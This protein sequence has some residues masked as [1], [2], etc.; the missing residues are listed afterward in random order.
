[1]F[2]YHR[3]VEVTTATMQHASG[4]VNTVLRRHGR[5]RPGAAI[6]ATTPTTIAEPGQNVW[7]PSQTRAASIHSNTVTPFEV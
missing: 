3:C 7:P 1:M 2:R 5:N 6:N 4:A